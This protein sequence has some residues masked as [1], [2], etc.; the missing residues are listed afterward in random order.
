VP[1][2]GR[3]TSP[4]PNYSATRPISPIP[5]A[6]MRPT[7]PAPIASYQRPTSPNPPPPPQ[8]AQHLPK[9]NSTNQIGLQK[10]II[11]PPSE[12]PRNHTNTIYI[13]NEPSKQQ[14]SPQNVFPTLREA[15]PPSWLMKHPN[16][17]NQ[18]NVVPSWAQRN[19]EQRARNEEPRQMVQE[20]MTRS[21]PIPV[22]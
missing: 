16:Q 9:Q 1:A 19:N 7:S 11:I 8:R 14:L 4:S 18:E 20:R 15:P 22:S 3:P 6:S 5:P 10:M 13:N 12:S 21:S 17:P 2:A